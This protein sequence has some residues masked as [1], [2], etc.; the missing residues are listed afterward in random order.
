[1]K[2]ALLG[3]GTVGTEVLRILDNSNDFDVRKILI[4]TS[5]CDSRATTDFNEILI[6]PEIELVVEVMGGIHPAYEYISACLKSGKH[7]VSAN[8]AVIAKYLN[9]FIELAKEN[10]VSFLFEASVGGGIPCLS[11]ILRISRFD[12]VFEFSGI[13]NGTTNYILSLMDK[14]ATSYEVALMDA[15]KKGYAE[16]DPTADVEG[17]DVQNKAAILAMLSYQCIVNVDDIPTVG[18]SNIT[19]MDIAYFQKKKVTCKLKACSKNHGDAMTLY[20]MPVLCRS[21]FSH[22]ESNDNIV[23][24][25]SQ[26]LGNLQLIGQGAG[27]APTASAVVSD[28]YDILENKTVSLKLT[29]TIPIDN[30]KEQYHFYVRTN[31]ID[32]DLFL[33]YEEEN[34]TYFAKTKR[35]SILDMMTWIQSHPNCFVAL[36]E[37]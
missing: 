28:C 27:G 6:D 23:S 5:K 37:E 9:E 18:I 30:S 22:V 11:E 21:L 13:L 33:S 36:W 10:H 26:N 17:I 12:Q 32:E 7:V 8:K 1:M 2:T 14:Q 31:K 4:R 20:V 25:T 34:E 24:I 35:M 29:K 3:C 19:D 15:Q 16:K